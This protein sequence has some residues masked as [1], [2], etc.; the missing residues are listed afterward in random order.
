L[1]SVSLSESSKRAKTSEQKQT[2][3]Q[4]NKQTNKN[5]T[6]RTQIQIRQEIQCAERHCLRLLGIVGFAPIMIAY[7]FHLFV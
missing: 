7:T 2:N 6:V 5:E 4:K 3:K 1:F